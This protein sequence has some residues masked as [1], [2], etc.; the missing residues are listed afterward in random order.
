MCGKRSK[1]NI[2]PSLPLRPVVVRPYTYLVLLT[3]ED[4]NMETPCYTWSEFLFLADRLGLSQGWRD[5][6][7]RWFQ[8]PGDCLLIVA[9]RDGV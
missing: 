8:Y 4:P 1:V 7:R 5:A 9:W 6:V 2:E 3:H